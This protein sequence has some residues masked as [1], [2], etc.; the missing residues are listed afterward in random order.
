[1]TFT[2]KCYFSVLRYTYLL[3]NRFFRFLVYLFDFLRL[4]THIGQATRRF[5]RFLRLLWPATTE[6]ESR[7]M[8]EQC[9]QK[10]E[11][12]H[13]GFKVTQPVLRQL[14]PRKM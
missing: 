2:L 13:G 7:T 8:E 10:Y 5:F 12:L 3:N 6:Q 9:Q 11:N 1:M 4:V 14:V